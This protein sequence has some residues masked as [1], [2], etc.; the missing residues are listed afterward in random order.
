MQDN[1]NKSNRR[2]G[3]RPGS[4]R[5]RNRRKVALSVKVTPEAMDALNERTVNKSEFIDNLLL[6]LPPGI[7]PEGLMAA[8]Q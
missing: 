8:R 1:V 7:S 2:G 3:W 4:G 5:P 6:H